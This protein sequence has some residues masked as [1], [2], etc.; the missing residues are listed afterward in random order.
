M[1][2]LVAAAVRV[3]LAA[4]KDELAQSVREAARLLDG[5]RAAKVAFLSGLTSGQIDELS[6][7]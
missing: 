7:L 4:R 1:K 5:S 3:Y 2:N 6:G